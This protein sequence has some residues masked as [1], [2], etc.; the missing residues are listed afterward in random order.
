MQ[1]L[2][3]VMRV[4]SVCGFNSLNKNFKARFVQNTDLNE[5]TVYEIRKNRSE[6]WQKGL[7]DLSEIK[8]DT[9]L[10]LEIDTDGQIVI[11]NLKNKNSIIWENCQNY[12]KPLKELANPESAAYYKLFL[13]GQS[14]NVMEEL[15]KINNTYYTKKK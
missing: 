4:N 5:V 11:T 6:C 12:S 9:L 2:G 3:G 7:K 1:K 8:K 13:A 14:I 10:D 15:Q